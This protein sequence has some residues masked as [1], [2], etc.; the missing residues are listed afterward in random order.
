[1]VATA[2]E[3]LGEDEEKAFVRDSATDDTRVRTAI[4]WLEEADLLSREENVVNVFPSSLRVETVEEARR[5]LEREDIADAYRVQLM[6]IA[7]ELIATG[8][9][10]SISTDELMALTGLSTDGVRGALYDLERLGIVSND[11]AITAFVHHGVE[12]SSRRRL[13]QAAALETELIAHMREHAH[14]QGKGDTALL[15]LR[16]A[17]QVLRDQGLADPLPERLWRIVRG[18]AN[19][20]RGEDG[21]AGSLSVRKQD[22][23]TARITLQREWEDLEGMAQ[24]RRAAAGRSLEHLLAEPQLPQGSRGTD[25]LAET[26]LGKLLQAIE[27]DLVL[28]SESKNPQKLLDRAL[29]WLHELEVIRL[30]KGL[31]VFRPAMTVRLAKGERRGFAKADFEPLSL[32]YKGQTLQVHVMA[33]FAQH[34]LDTMRD[35]MRLATDY[36]T[37]KEGTFLDRWLPGRDKEIGRLLVCRAVPIL[38]LVTQ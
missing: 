3:I 14:D 8:S 9:D 37:L 10:E 13:E 32:H 28:K 31:A 20:G 22:A 25:L 33:A 30:N 35:A 38:S 18:I 29:M 15:H 23:E 27:S 6:R 21:A 34:G 4:A 24:R 36:F 11:T 1:M 17:A 16:I 12:R 2:G 7:E 5:K 26:T 19:D